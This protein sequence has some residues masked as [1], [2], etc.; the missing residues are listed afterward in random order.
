MFEIPSQ[1][2]IKEV[3]VNEDVI[4]K[5]NPPIKAHAEEAAGAER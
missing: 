3:L 5:R 2:S 1:P 4:D